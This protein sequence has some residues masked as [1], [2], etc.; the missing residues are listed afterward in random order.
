MILVF[1]SV[2]ILGRHPL[3]DAS[4]ASGSTYVLSVTLLPEE[5]K[6]MLSITRVSSPIWIT[7]RCRHLRSLASPTWWYGLCQESQLHWSDSLLP[8]PNL[9]DGQ[10]SHL[11]LSLFCFLVAHYFQ[12][13]FSSSLLLDLLEYVTCTWPKGCQDSI[14]SWGK[15]GSGWW[16]FIWENGVHPIHENTRAYWYLH[17]MKSLHL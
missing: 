16:N 2:Q 17:H 8:L 11:Q 14:K 3:H 1:R 12:V 6:G 10:V 7:S 9:C 4:L 13:A 15:M 5:G